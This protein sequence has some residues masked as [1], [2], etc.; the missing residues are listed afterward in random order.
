VRAILLLAGVGFFALA[1]V[2]MGVLPI[3]TLSD[4]PM[5]SLAEVAVTVPE[6]FR[7]AAARWP[8]SFARSFG[9]PSLENWHAALRRG[10]VIYV[11]EGCWHCH[12]QFVRPVSNEGLRFGPVSIA[13]EYQNEMQMPVLFGTRRVGPDLTRE[14]GKRTNDWHVAHFWDPRSIVPT[15]VMPRYPWFFEPQV[16]GALPT[17]PNRDGLCILAYVQWLG[18]WPR[19]DVESTE[20]AP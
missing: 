17:G 15:S 14:G 11:G 6:S 18:T 13:E 7:D 2:L 16:G 9:E 1:F 5:K 4:I 3:V 19:P 8:A 20:G 12:S 10:H